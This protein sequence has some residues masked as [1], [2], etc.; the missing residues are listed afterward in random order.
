[1]SH[2]DEVSTSDPDELEILLATKPDY[3]RE[4]L[5][6][7]SSPKIITNTD[8]RF[9]LE[10]VPNSQSSDDSPRP[11]KRVKVSSIEA[12]TEQAVT[13]DLPLAS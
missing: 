5:F 10:P 6:L 9:T 8:T 12:K 1:M 7:S 13:V 4:N 3:W 11:R 2:N